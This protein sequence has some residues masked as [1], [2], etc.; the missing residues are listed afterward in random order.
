MEQKNENQEKKRKFLLLG[1]GIGTLVGGT[2]GT[3]LM[4]CGH[5]EYSWLPLMGMNL[6]MGIGA[7]AGGGRKKSENTEELKK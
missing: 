1:M 5:P 2:A 3:I 4:I 6:G 7:I